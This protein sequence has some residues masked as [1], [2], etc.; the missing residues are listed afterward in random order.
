MELKDFVKQTLLEIIQDVKEAKAEAG[1][2][3]VYD[4]Y[5][6]S[7]SKSMAER[8]PIEFDVAVTTAEEEGQEGGA[9]IKVIGLF[10]VGGELSSN[11]ATTQTSRIKFQVPV[12]YP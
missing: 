11:S 10:K 6:V 7:P 4:D 2:Q 8:F 5:I 12:V 9:G 3:D 1:K